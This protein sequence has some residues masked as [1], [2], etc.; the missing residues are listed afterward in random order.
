MGEKG[1]EKVKLLLFLESLCELLILSK[2][3]K[4]NFN[5]IINQC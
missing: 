5:F 3:S 2:S 1:N 4:T